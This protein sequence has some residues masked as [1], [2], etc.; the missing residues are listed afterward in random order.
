LP[1]CSRIIGVTDTQRICLTPH[2]PASPTHSSP[3]QFHPHLP[4]SL[5][6]KWPAAPPQ[7]QIRLHLRDHSGRA[8]RTGT[9]CRQLPSVSSGISTSS[10]R[11]QT[12]LRTCSSKLRSTLPALPRVSTLSTELNARGV[13]CDL[14]RRAASRTTRAGC[15]AVVSAWYEHCGES[16]R[17]LG[18]IC[19]G[20]VSVR[21]LAAGDPQPQGSVPE[22][23]GRCLLRHHNPR[24]QDSAP[25]LCLKPK[26]PAPKTPAVTPSPTTHPTRRRMNEAGYATNDNVTRSRG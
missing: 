21:P 16:C 25:P 5:S 4:A 11:A 13:A 24:G 20:D 22:D 18:L 7:P 26:T 23:R 12:R 6:P 9:S 2:A 14:R 8:A 1:D 3:Q 10:Q 19:D 15:R 17:S